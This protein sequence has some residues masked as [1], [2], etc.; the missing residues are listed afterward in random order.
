MS[1]SFQKETFNDRET[2]RDFLLLVVWGG[3]LCLCALTLQNYYMDG[4]PPLWDNLIY[5]QKALYILTNWL[6][7]NSEQALKS[8]YADKFPAFLFTIAISFLLFGLNPFAPYLV[9]AFF[10]AGCMIVVYLLSREIGAGKRTAF[11]GILAFSLL[12]NFIYQNFLQTR[13]DFP[14][15]FFIALSWLFF[16]RAVKHKS[17][18]LT[19]YAGFISGIGTLFKASAPGYVAWGILIFLAMPEKYVQTSLKERMKMAF[20]FAGG[21]VISCGWHFLPHLDQI[22]NYYTSWGN[23]KVWVISEYNLRGDWT[24]L[25]FYV[26]NIIFTIYKS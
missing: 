12:P 15:A 6:D 14:L 20:L 24:D 23:A 8:L 26:R 1:E 25:F 13:N 22:L 11:W 17:I 18:K 16:V 9:S 3:V 4:K 2:L 10:G 19:F 5:Q 7:G 21:A